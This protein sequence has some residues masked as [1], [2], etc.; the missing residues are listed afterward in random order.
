MGE[1]GH[2]LAAML[3]RR[4]LLLVLVAAVTG[5]SVPGPPRVAVDAHGITLVLVLLVAAVGLGIAP[6]AIAAA[7]AAAARILLALLLG[8]VALPAMAYLASRLVPQGPLRLG[9]LAAGVAPSEVAAVAL[10]ALAGGEAAVAA[11]VL[12][13]ST[14][15][16]VVTAGPV[17]GLLAGS[18]ATISAAGLIGSLARIVALPLFVGIALRALCRGRLVD[19]VETV[20][21][22]TASIT[23]LILVW[24][25]ASQAHLSLA[26]L[27]A[28][29]GLL[30]FLAGSALTGVITSVRLPRQRAVA[31]LMPTTMRDFAIAAGIATTAFG[32]AA[33]APLGLYGVFVLVLGT[34]V[35]RAAQRRDTRRQGLPS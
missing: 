11:G 28:G 17:L 13:G 19:V 32:P 26:Y 27:R 10:V 15:I 14:L 12:V 20:S 23:V 31:I 16:S 7:R 34:V 30:V 6:S 29:L 3:D 2:D 33:A 4:L 25:V 22:V 21:A 8:A 9:V 24:L 18:G 1:L 35:T 5:L